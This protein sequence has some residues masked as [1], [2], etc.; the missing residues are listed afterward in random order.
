MLRH[1]HPN[2]SLILPRWQ[3]ITVTLMSICVFDRLAEK[4]GHGVAGMVASRQAY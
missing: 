4:P 2:P 3:S 1:Y